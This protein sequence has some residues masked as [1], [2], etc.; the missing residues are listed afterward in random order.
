MNKNR[1]FYLV[2]ENQ[3]SKPTIESIVF[4]GG[5]NTTS[6]FVLR[7]D[8]VHPFLSGNKWRK[9]KYNIEN[10][11][12]S[13]KKTILTFGGAYS[14]HLVATATAG[15]MYNIPILAI[16][17]GE[18]VE[19][20]RIH[21]IK[22]CGTVIHFISRSDYRLKTDA[23][24][25]RQLFHELIHLKLIADA[26][27]IF[28]IPE[29]GSNEA[30]VKGTE[31]IVADIPNEI[32]YIITACG[33][34]GTLAGISRKLKSHQRAIGISV[35]KGGAFLLKEII[36]LGGIPEKIDLLTDFHFGG[37]ARSNP[38]LLNFCITFTAETGIPI[39]P[40]YTGKVFYAVHHLLQTDLFQNKKIM[41]V[42]TGGVFENSK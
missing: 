31:E 10:F 40:V 35:L 36:K 11:N 2:K 41:I 18:E 3:F 37:Y 33:S 32:D 6:V 9:L 19:N 22:E 1:Y 15:K 23:N 30:A 28:L 13:G 38:E 20:E 8:L 5:N 7:D 39:E 29:G 12:T 26:N 27:D 24:S 34:G 21:F 14:N 25:L 42:H 17:R 4:P 16:I